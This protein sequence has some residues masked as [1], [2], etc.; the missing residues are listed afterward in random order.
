MALI[1]RTHNHGPSQSDQGGF[2]S[3]EYKVMALLL[4]CLPAQKW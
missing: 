2:W 4:T 3:C 1:N